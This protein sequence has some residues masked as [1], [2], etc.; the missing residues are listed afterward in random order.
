MVMVMLADVASGEVPLAALTVNV[1]D[2][3]V[4]GVPDNTPVVSSNVRPAGRDPLPTVNIGDG[5]P[6]ALNV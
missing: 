5:L 6:E 4:V 2:P 3:A 1:D